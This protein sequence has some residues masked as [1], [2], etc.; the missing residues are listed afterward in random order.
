M[1]GQK[2][3]LLGIMLL[4]RRILNLRRVNEHVLKIILEI[5]MIVNF[6]HYEFV[7]VKM[8]KL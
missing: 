6:L 4:G 7:E 8:V 2:E 5:E 1:I 3:K